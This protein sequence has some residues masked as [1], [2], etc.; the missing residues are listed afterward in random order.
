MKDHEYLGLKSILLKNER[1]NQEFK[2]E[3]KKYMEDNES[4]SMTVQSSGMQQGWS[5]EGGI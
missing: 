1:G 2:E 3:I 4:E 5:Y